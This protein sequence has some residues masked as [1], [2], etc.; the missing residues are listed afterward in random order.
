MFIKVIVSAKYN[1][2]QVVYNFS[3]FLTNYLVKK[4]ADTYF[5]LWICYLKQAYHL[6]CSRKVTYNYLLR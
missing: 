4:E 5:C 3:I 6:K 1:Y 2:L